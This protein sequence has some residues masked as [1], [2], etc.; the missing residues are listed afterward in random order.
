MSSLR[1]NTDVFDLSKMPS[2]AFVWGR[3]VN[4]VTS[5]LAS[6]AGVWTNFLEQIK[7]KQNNFYIKQNTIKNY[8]ADCDILLLL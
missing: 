1:R 3:S 8:V 2:V 4:R 5:A 6:R 7:G